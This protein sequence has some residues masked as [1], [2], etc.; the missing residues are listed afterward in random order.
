[1]FERTKTAKN[2]VLVINIDRIAVGFLSQELSVTQVSGSANDCPP[3][4]DQL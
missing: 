3:D 2:F 4:G 1:M